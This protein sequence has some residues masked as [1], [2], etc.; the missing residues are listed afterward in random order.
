MKFK[1][2]YN[3]PAH[4]QEEGGL[5]RSPEERLLWIKQRVEGGYYES[6]RVKQAVAEAFL[7][8]PTVR[9]AGEQAMPGRK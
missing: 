9:R 4:L 5:P 1:N 6:A 8:P 3:L 7:D 2:D